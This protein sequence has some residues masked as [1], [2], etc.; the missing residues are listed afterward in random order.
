MI[1][2]L[3]SNSSYV[4]KPELAGTT[5]KATILVGDKEQKTMLRSA[6][7]LHDA[8]PDSTLQ[9]LQQYGHGEF[10]LNHPKDYVALLTRMVS[11]LR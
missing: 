1:R 5:A 2:F 8:I 6:E 11:P 9:V 4:M 3:K 10:S 7:I